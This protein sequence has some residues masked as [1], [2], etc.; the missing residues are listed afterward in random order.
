MVSRALS[1]VRQSSSYNRLTA[2]AHCGVCGDRD[3]DG[4]E[5]GD[6][7]ADGR[8]V[9]YAYATRL[10][11]WYIHITRITPQLTV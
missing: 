10:E 11:N 2:A 5:D 1:A 3:R 8:G 7:G 4:D 6:G 9:T